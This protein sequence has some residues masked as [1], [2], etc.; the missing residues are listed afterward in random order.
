VRTFALQR[1][2]CGASHDGGECPACRARRLGSA[3]TLVHQ[4]LSRPGRPLESGARTELEQSLGHDFSAV[5]VHTD[6][7]A[8]ASAAAVSA[9][10][11]TVGSNIVF[12]ADRYRPASAEGRRLLA[13]ELTHVRQQAGAAPGGP[14]RIVD[15]RAAEAEA[16]RA[17]A[18][19]VR[20]MQRALQRQEDEPERP[21]EGGELGIEAPPVITL[22]EGAAPA[23]EGE[24][25][26]EPTPMT[27]TP[28]PATNCQV[29]SWGDFRGRPP[30]GGNFQAE[31]HFSIPV[32]SGRFVAVFNGGAS[33]VRPKYPGSGARAT[34]GCGSIVRQCQR[35]FRNLPAGHTGTFDVGPSAQCPATVV[36]PVQATT[37][38]ECE[39]VIGAQCDT[40]APNESAR[41]LNHEQRHLDIACQLAKKAN[42][43]LDSGS[44]LADVRRGVDR[45]QAAVTTSYD[46]AAE[47]DHGCDSGS[48]A[49]WDADID[50]GLPNVTI[51]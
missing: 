23:E 17:P 42:D 39:S 33:W 6:Q 5:R 40:D 19:P 45:E 29:L 28:G 18:A 36:T 25:P 47:T 21:P 8:A 14:L 51:P 22:E 1:C 2:A 31:T 34:N 16:H 20:T 32:R 13:H 7:T 41:L 12:G 11:Y 50:A 48:Q 15:D 49:T 43:A 4:T 24:T 3:A 37:R 30:R 44:V 35:A 9:R 46:S 10:A 38:A 27:P 26:A